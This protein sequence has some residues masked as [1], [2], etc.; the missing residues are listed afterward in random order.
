MKR[1]IG[2]HIVPLWL[3]GADDESNLGPA[4]EDCARKKTRA[5]A[6]VRKKV[7][8]MR[9]KYLGVKRRQRRPMPGTIASGWRKRFDG[10]VERR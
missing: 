1:W 7:Y 8:R 6:G 9:A 2:E 5:E 4:H 10:T 3:G